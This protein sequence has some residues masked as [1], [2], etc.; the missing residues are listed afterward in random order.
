M[1]KEEKPEPKQEEKPKEEPKKEVKREAISEKD[2]E[3]YCQDARLLNKYVHLDK[4]TIID[5]WNYNKRYEGDWGFDSEGN[6]IVSL[7]WN[8]KDKTDGSALRFICWVAGTKDNIR[9]MQMDI[10]GVT[11]H[12]IP[13]YDANGKQ[14]E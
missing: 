9:L 13:F 6:P 4:T 8:G 3:L 1:K 5:I 7:S 12:A 2:A 11:V 14:V 10:G